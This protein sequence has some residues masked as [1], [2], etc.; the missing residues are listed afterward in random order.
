MAFLPLVLHWFFIDVVAG[1]R[2]QSRSNMREVILQFI[3]ATIEVIVASISTLLLSSPMGSVTLKTCRA[4]ALSDWYTLLHNPRPHY[5]YTLHCTQEAVYPLY[6][7]VLVMYVFG[8]MMMLLLRP[9]VAMGA[10]M[11]YTTVAIYC[12]LYFYPVLVLIHAVAAGI[13][14]YSFPYIVIILSMM[15]S[16]AH[17]SGKKDQS[18]MSLLVTSV[19]DGRNVLIL[20]GHWLMHAYGIISV[21]GL[22]DPVFHGAL[23]ALVPTPAAFYIFTAQFTDPV[24]V[25]GD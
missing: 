5:K 25:H 12:A 4:E 21:T 16:A 23:L 3:C 17:F 8:L 11:E 14:Y 15:S 18:A 24:K 22:R 1:R 7:I 9:W 10:S 6:T 19:T 13:I 2:Y 20:L